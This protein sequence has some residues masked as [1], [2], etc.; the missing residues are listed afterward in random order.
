[1]HAFTLGSAKERKL[2]CRT[3]NETAL[4]PQ[5]FGNPSLM[6]ARTFCQHCAIEKNLFIYSMY[7]ALMLCNRYCDCRLLLSLPT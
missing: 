2:F 6:L 4:A 7:I 5:D 1:M 3:I